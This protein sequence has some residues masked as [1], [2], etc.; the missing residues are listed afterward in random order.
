MMLDYI[1]KLQLSGDEANRYRNELR[2]LSYLSKGLHY[3]YGQVKSSEATVSSR[4]NPKMLVSMSGNAPQLQ[5]IPQG[6]VAC[7]F[8]WYSVSACNYVRLVGWLVNGGDTAKAT[9]YLKRVLPQVY[10]WRNK[11]GAH[12]ARTDP[13]KEDTS[14]DLVK[15]VMFPISFDDDAFYASSHVLVMTRGGQKSSSRKDMRWSLTHTYQELAS[16]YWP[17]SGSG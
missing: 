16:R 1:D 13:K 8:H 12:F 10:V 17:N 3:L 7:A 2:S 4:L 6:L 5:N 11:V 14:A 15:S 9:G